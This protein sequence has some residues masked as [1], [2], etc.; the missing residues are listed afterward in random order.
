MRCTDFAPSADKGLI[1]EQVGVSHDDAKRAAQ[2]MGNLAE[3]AHLDVQRRL[4]LLIE[5]LQRLGALLGFPVQT[6]ILQH[7]RDKAAEGLCQ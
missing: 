4:Q 6:R 5:T 1:G 3:K 2:F 7:H